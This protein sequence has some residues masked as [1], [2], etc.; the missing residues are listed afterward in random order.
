MPLIVIKFQV[1]D[2]ATTTLRNLTLENGSFL[3]AAKETR[4]LEE[5]DM[6]LKPLTRKETR[7]S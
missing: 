5:V 1:L 6:H 2:R 4:R 3:L 7:S